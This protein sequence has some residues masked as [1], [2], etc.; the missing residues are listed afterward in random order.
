MNELH[1]FVLVADELSD[2]AME[3]Q[4]SGGFRGTLLAADFQ[5]Q[6]V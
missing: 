4:H 1:L 6:I 5:P 3:V 2:P